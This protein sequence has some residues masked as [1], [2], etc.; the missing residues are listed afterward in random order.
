MTKNEAALIELLLPHEFPEG[1]NTI[2]FQELRAAVL[3]ERTPPE[4]R[5]A[6]VTYIRE[7][8]EHKARNHV[9]WSGLVKKYGRAAVEQCASNIRN[10]R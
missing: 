6:L 9:T 4:L 2:H 8:E 5:E 7:L 3:S 1:V 10:K